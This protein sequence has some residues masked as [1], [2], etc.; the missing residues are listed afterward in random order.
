MSEFRLKP[1]NFD[2]EL[3]DTLRYEHAFEHADLERAKA[4]VGDAIEHVERKTGT[5]SGMGAKH[6]DTAM[7]FLHKDH[8]DWKKLPD[9]KKQHIEDAL[10]KTFSIAEPEEGSET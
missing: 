5:S 1:E 6:F 10:K 9:H 8:A 4:I 7:K 3:R 2:R